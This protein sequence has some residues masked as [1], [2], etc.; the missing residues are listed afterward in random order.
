MK[1]I[2]KLFSLFLTISFL[3]GCGGGSSNVPNVVGTAAGTYSGNI[4]RQSWDCPF[5]TA[6][7]LRVSDPVITS[8]SKI[9]ILGPNSIVYTAT[10]TSNGFYY[11]YSSDTYIGKIGTCKVK[12][13]RSYSNLTD[14]TGDVTLETTYTCDSLTCSGTW[15]ATLTKS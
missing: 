10:T 14:T 15:F 2:T 4:E 7:S 1:A 8:E 11:T 6:T 13:V 12:N 9:Q 5:K 3:F